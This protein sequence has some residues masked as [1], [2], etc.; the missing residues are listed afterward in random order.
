LFNSKTEA[1]SGGG[2]GSSDSGGPQQAGSENPDTAN[3]VGAQGMPGDDTP[4]AS[5]M[6]ESMED[7][8]SVFDPADEQKDTTEAKDG[9]ISDET[10]DDEEADSDGEKKEDLNASEKESSSDD[11]GVLIEG[12]NVGRVASQI[13]NGI[14]KKRGE[15]WKGTC[16]AVG[17]ATNDIYNMATDGHPLARTALMLGGVTTTGPLAAV[18]SITVGPTLAGSGAYASVFGW[19]VR[20]A[21]YTQTIVDSVAAIAIPG[22]A[23]T[24]V[25]GLVGITKD[26]FDYIVEGYRDN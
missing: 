4:D 16:S 9:A 22:P 17:Q 21:P 26:A 19:A 13:Y 10:F 20:T 6:P 11:D 15:I 14:R 8:P 25:G 3:D 23:A 18:G 7:E 24:W 12:Y 2:S 1:S 5:D